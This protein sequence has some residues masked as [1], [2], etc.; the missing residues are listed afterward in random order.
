MLLDRLQVGLSDMGQ[1][2]C[3]MED[4]SMDENL[5]VI[6]Y[7]DIFQLLDENPAVDKLLFTSSSGKASAVCWFKDY[8]AIHGIKYN[9]PKGMRPLRSQLELRGR[10]VEIVL[11]Y[12]TSPRVG[13]VISFEGLTRLFGEHL[14]PTL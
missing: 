14:P 13:A 1:L 2:I 10:M 5:Q 3:R 9:I 7:M 12:S 11:L 6:E 4:N 8:L